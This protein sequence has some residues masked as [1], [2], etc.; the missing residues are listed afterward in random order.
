[1]AQD[2]CPGILAPVRPIPLLFTLF[3]VTPVV[4]VVIFILVGARIGL[5][6]TVVLVVLTAVIGAA[7]V[8]RQGRTTLRRAR[9]K[10][11]EGRFPA[12]PLAHGVMILVAGALLLTPGFLTDAIGFALLVSPVR[13]RLRLWAA[14]RFTPD[15]IINL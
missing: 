15:Q 13:E 14:A 7:L 10:L 3:L 8:S 9:G 2:T 1:M 4:E 12:V 5:A 6:A 11:L